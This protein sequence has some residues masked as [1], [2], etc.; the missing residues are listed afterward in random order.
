MGVTGGVMAVVAVVGA[1]VLG[2]ATPA[3]AAATALV[4]LVL[5]VLV[6]VVVVEA[7]MVAT[8]VRRSSRGRG[9]QEAC[10]RE[11]GRRLER[12]SRCWRA[13]GGAWWC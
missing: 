1:T 5:V 7:E 11:G 13:A 12:R 8:A 9:L 2:E 4:V 6:V 10:P 3:A